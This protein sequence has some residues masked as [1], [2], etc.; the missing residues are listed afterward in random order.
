MPLQLLKLQKVS[1]SSRFAEAATFFS[2]PARLIHYRAERR[3]WCSRCESGL[4]ESV[5]T[6]HYWCCIFVIRTSLLHYA[7][8]VHGE[9]RCLPT[10]ISMRTFWPGFEPAACGTYTVGV[11]FDSVKR[12][13][14]YLKYSNVSVTFQSAVNAS[15]ASFM[16]VTTKKRDRIL[17]VLYVHCCT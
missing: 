16:I 3:R 11:F 9:Y 13:I 1:F 12:Q 5:L 6:I 2:P 7:Y 4:C 17:K 8:Q 14:S 15:T 10:L